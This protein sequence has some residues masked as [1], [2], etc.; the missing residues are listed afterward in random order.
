MST[1]SRYCFPSIST[2]SGATSSPYRSMTSF[3]RYAD[4]S[5]TTAVRSIT[6]T[7]RCTSSSR[8]PRLLSPAQPPPASSP[9]IGLSTRHRACPTQTSA[10]PAPRVSGPRTSPPTPR[11]DTS[12]QS[13]PAARSPSHPPRQPEALLHSDNRPSH[14]IVEDGHARA[15]MR[16]VRSARV[17]GRGSEFGDHPTALSESRKKRCRSPPLLSGSQTKQRESNPKVFVRGSRGNG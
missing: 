5:T 10:P 11:R 7:S 6:S 13:S 4:E 9:C 16:I 2:L 15:A 12:Y 1:P 8:P 14:R 3:G 17:V